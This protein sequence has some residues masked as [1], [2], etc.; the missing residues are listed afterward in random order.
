MDLPYKWLK[1][2]CDID[3]SPN[4]LAHRLTMT[5]T[6]VEGY[7]CAADNIKNVVVGNVVSLERHPDSDHLWVCQVDVGAETTQIVTGAQNVHAGDN[8]PAALH[9]SHLPNGAHIKRGKLR[10]IASNG[11]MCSLGELGLTTGDFPDCIEDGIMILD[12]SLAP[13]TPIEQALM[14]DDTVFEFEIT[15]NRPDCLCATGIAREAAATYN[16]PFKFKQ[17]PDI[18]VG[19][20][21]ASML[22]VTIE[23]PS[24]CYRY[25][26]A[27][28]RNV[29]IKPSPLWMRTRLR[30]CGVRP[31]NNIV[32]ITN[33]VMLEYNQPMH[34]FD[35]RNVK[36]DHII[37]RLA[38]NGEKITTLDDVERTLTCDM[39][40]IA[41]S[42]KPIAVA[43]VM[44]GEFSGIYPDTNTVIFE[45]ACFEGINNRATAK[46]LG[47][48]TDASTRYEKG[49]DP[50]NTMTALSRAL[51][52]VR[53]LD[54]G[55]VVTGCV[56]V[57]GDSL[58]HNEITVDPAKI[59]A[60]LGTNIQADDMKEYLRRLNFGV[61]GDITVS[62]PG[63]RLDVEGFADVAE[64]IARIYGYDRIPT[65][66]LCGAANAKLTARQHF[67]SELTSV[68][69]ACGYSEISTTSFMNPKT[70]DLMRVPEGDTLRRA[71]KIINPFG[72]ETSLLRTTAVSSMLDTMQRNLKSR[73]PAA[74][75]FELATEYIADPD[76][77][78]LPAELKKIIIGAY[79]DGNDFY[80]LK[81]AVE[82][83][84][85]ASRVE[86][87][88]AP[89]TDS[90][91][92]HPGRCASVCVGGEKIGIMGEI[93]PLVL[94]NYGIKKRVLAADIDADR[95]FAARGP[96]QQFAG[97]PK[98]PALERDLALVCDM[99]VL[100][101]DVENVIKKQCGSLLVGIKVFDVYIGEQL[102]ADKKSIAFELKLR[103]P[104]RTLTDTEADA[105]VSRTLK[106]L[107]QSGIT[108][109]S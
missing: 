8:V 42:E 80:T 75:L 17:A 96:L 10:G 108:L 29:R 98:F 55:D 26:G 76:I 103:A 99:D 28:V 89:V 34:A 67:M 69:I 45:S 18:E 32:D 53:E 84:C 88:F 48:R 90:P 4:E 31:I 50:E 47:M 82:A 83:A 109:R 13:G 63:N 81:G 2:Y 24:L 14:L 1:E 41:D 22:R 104:D 38:K 3:A 64:E 35:A 20:E 92:F 107:A 16:V 12:P 106:A 86:V 91:Y 71:V 57:R 9:D 77:G 49:L 54:A 7:S 79:G 93:H 15:S 70:F 74:K 5:G 87:S 43:G 39:L 61:T 94:K 105:A 85:K 97:L 36:D 51:E 40:I 65:T 25:T 100:C 58:P 33:Y 52:L 19:G 6:K 73:H 66:A 21:A 23:H 37:V 95:L 46:A 27:F 59:N 44:G 60:F 78:Q 102:P 72:E 30:E 56:D 11:M 68:L 62:V 101:A